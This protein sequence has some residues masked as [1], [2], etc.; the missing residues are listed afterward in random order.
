MTGIKELRKPI[1][2]GILGGIAS[3]K[4]EVTRAL[5]ALNAV[6]ISADE[7]AHQVLLEK[8]IV[9]SLVEIFG[10]CILLESDSTRGDQ[11]RGDQSRG[12]SVV[13]DRKKLG[14]IV[15]GSSPEKREMR[16][17][18]EAIV[19]PRIRE[20]ARRKLETLLRDPS[21]QMIVLD[22]PLL[23]EGGWL[24]FCDK[25]L[26]VDSPEK[27]RMNHALARGWTVEEW[28]NREL[29]QLSLE[30]K[31]KYA[32]HLVLNDGTI[33]HLKQQVMAF[34]ASLQK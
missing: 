30:E 10:S 29:A 17:K 15:F 11:S 23:I 31:R 14:A 27:M 26:F 9:E 18:L 5:G 7:I 12:N 8:T 21:L 24:P 25:V 19:H 1:V 28:R 32:T 13:I 34:V 4:S 6:I 20:I 33:E 2:I 16:K 22:A 3:G